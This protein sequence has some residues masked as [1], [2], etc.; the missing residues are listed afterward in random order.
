MIA[1]QAAKVSGAGRGWEMIY[2]GRGDFARCGAWCWPATLR[3]AE[4]PEERRRAQRLQGRSY[5]FFAAFF[6]VFLAPVF[7]AAAFLAP[8][9][10]AASFPCALFTKPFLFAL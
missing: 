6:A 1:A 3:T 7:F 5:F 2:S 8:V 4:D 9:F 10:F